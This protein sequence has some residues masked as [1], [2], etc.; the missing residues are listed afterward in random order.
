M[1]WSRSVREYIKTQTDKILSVIYLLN[2]IDMSLT[3]WNSITLPYSHDDKL[4][5]QDL[6]NNIDQVLTLI[7]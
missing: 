7:E 1:R 6:L 3:I 2:N 5:K 4:C